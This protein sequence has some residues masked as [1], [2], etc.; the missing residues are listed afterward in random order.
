VLILFWV[1]HGVSLALRP[2]LS[3]EE[4]NGYRHHGRADRGGKQK[5]YFL[6]TKK[7]F[8]TLDEGK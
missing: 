7:L 1:R 3:V 5:I 6:D 4:N 2:V 8:S